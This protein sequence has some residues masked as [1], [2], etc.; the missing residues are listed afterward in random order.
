[1]YRNSDF[2]AMKFNCT[3]L[4]ICPS[5]PSR[6]S[7]KNKFVCPFPPGAP[8][9]VAPDIARKRGG[10]EVYRGRAVYRRKL[11]ATEGYLFALSGPRCFFS[12]HKKPMAGKCLQHCFFFISRKQLAWTTMNSAL[13]VGDQCTFW[14]FMG[15][16]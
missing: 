14:S 12:L 4:H 5:P 7:I 16:S 6:K 10:K 3:G 8:R 11:L 2:R 15:S 1:M 9:L 13:I